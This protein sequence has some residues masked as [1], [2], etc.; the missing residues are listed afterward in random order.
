VDR[1]VARELSCVYVLDVSAAAL[2]RARARLGAAA[3]AVTWIDADVTSDLWPVPRVDAWHDRAVFHFLTDAADR[4]AYVDRLR[5]AVTPG[6]TVVIATF[7]V[8]GPER[9]SGLP[10]RRYAPDDL[11]AELGPPFRLVDAVPDAHRTPSGAVQ[12]FVYARFVRTA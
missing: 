2:A 4:A 9:C 3:A 11:A 7:G 10:V 5:A 12:S 1:L 6:G 8:D